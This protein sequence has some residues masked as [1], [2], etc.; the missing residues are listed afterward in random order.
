L[1]ALKR[2]LESFVSK[3]KY[4]EAVLARREAVA[5][6]ERKEQ[7]ISELVTIWQREINFTR[8]VENQLLKKRI[9]DLE[10][11]GAHNPLDT[12]PDWD[13]I[14]S[15]SPVNVSPF[16]IQCKD[17]DC[18]DSIIILI[19]EICRSRAAAKVARLQE[20][21]PKIDIPGG[22]PRFF[23][24]LGLA[25]DVPKYLRFK[26]KIPNRMLSRKNLLLLIKDAWAA[27]MLHDAAPRR[28]G[29][30]TTLSDFLYMYLKKRFGSQEAVA[31]WGYNLVD[32]CRR[33]RFQS[34]DCQLFA[35]IASG[36]LEEEVYHDQMRMVERL[37]AVFHRLDVDVNGGRARGIV[38]KAHAIESLR[39]FW[40]GKG[41]KE[42]DQMKNAL[43][44][45]QPGDNLT[46]RWLFQ[47][48]SECVLLDVVRE[49]EMEA[50]ESYMNGLSL[51]GD[52]IRAKA[53]RSWT[54]TWRED[55]GYIERVV[56]AEDEEFTTEV[57][58]EDI[59]MRAPIEASK[60]LANL[61]RGV[62]R[63]GPASE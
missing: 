62:L 1:S 25:A 31:E 28:K 56:E 47:N 46:Y 21:P 44:A 5:K 11:Q 27:K 37:K 61:R 36:A 63:K 8:A 10:K 22:E 42:I 6:A 39:A 60:F 35:D 24:G 12:L 7:E 13:Y 15:M 52:T 59:K 9:A 50:R 30:R 41:D 40:P 14:Q 38:P 43:E 3:A 51:W 19:R 58:A 29:Q 53:K 34:V 54:N 18:N 49:Q 23:V 2:N 48:D 16:G 32:A 17:R 33:H 26:G 55:L 57:R 45:D 4:D 20:P